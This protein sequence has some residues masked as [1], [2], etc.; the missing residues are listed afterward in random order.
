MAVQTSL[1][2]WFKMLELFSGFSVPMFPAFKMQVMAFLLRFYALHFKDIPFNIQGFESFG[3]V[4][5]TKLK[6]LYIALQGSGQHSTSG[7]TQGL[8][9]CIF[10]HTI[11]ITSI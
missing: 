1:S 3:I 9:L 7:R 5:C 10:N 8:N 4:R 2:R 6:L 11:T